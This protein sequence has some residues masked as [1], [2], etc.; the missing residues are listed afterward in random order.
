MT[1][2]GA[3][4]AAEQVEWSVPK[5]RQKLFTAKIAKKS[6]GGRKEERLPLGTQRV[7]VE[8]RPQ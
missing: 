3:K 6:R 8:L 2:E 7:T 4:Y 1:A 5:T